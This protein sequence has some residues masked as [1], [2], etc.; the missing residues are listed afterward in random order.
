MVQEEVKLKVVAVKE[1][2][3][4]YG[5]NQSKKM[6]FSKFVAAVA[7]E[8]HNTDDLEKLKKL[9][10]LISS[11]LERDDTLAFSPVK[12]L[13]YD[14]INKIVRENAI[15]N[16]NLNISPD[17]SKLISDLC[18]GTVKLSDAKEVIA[19]EAEKIKTNQFIK[20]NQKEEQIGIR[21]R[22]IIKQSSLQCEI[23]N[24]EKTVQLLQEV[25]K[26]TSE[27]ALDC[28]VSNYI[29]LKKYD[30]A[31]AVCDKF[32]PKEGKSNF[33]ELKSLDRIKRKVIVAQIGDIILKG[34]KT[35]GTPEEENAYFQ[36]IENNLRRTSINLSNIDL[37]KSQDGKRRITLAD[38]WE[39]RTR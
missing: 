10:K 16:I 31:L 36:M 24:G 28:V 8:A 12:R 19:K 34:I 33:I 6:I 1:T 3:I 22:N 39:E 21:I 25:T 20:E 5:F 27:V 9:N 13:L 23:V 32:S 11:E 30:D 4:R 17:M 2:Y 14:K 15:N 37:G 35:Q 29:K 38:I 26:C 7:N 18:S